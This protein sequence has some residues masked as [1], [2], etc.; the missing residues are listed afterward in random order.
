MQYMDTIFGKNNTVNTA[1]NILNITPNKQPEVV[2]LTS[3]NN[4]DKKYF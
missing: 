3:T 2:Q 1:E 4:S